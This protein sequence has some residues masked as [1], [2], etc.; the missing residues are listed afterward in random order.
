MNES[1]IK[2]FSCQLSEVIEMTPIVKNKDEIQKR[3]ANIDEIRNKLLSS[4]SEEEKQNYN[5][6]NLQDEMTYKLLVYGMLAKISADYDVLISNSTS[7]EQPPLFDAK[8]DFFIKCKAQLCGDSFFVNFC[9][10]V[11]FTQDIAKF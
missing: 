4:Q 11:K 6:Q 10:L 5:L 9:N 3:L 1:D 2:E 7:D 8:Y